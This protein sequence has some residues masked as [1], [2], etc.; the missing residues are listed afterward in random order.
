MTRKSKLRKRAQATPPP[1]PA[2]KPSAGQM[3]TEHGLTVSA[4][5]VNTI[6]LSVDDIIE[7]LPAAARE[8]VDRDPDQDL[9]RH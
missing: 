8:V 2:H 9:A 3:T 7:D 1:I 6:E 5:P 4:S